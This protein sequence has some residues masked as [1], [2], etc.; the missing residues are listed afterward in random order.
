MERNTLFADVIVPLAVPKTYTYRIPQEYNEIVQPGIRVVVQFG[1][2]KLYAAV[3]KNIHSEAPKAYEAK[4]IDAILDEFPV[5]TPTQFQFW[6]WLSSYYMCHPGDVL[7]AALPGGLKISSESKII[8]NPHYEGD[9]S[10]LKDNEFLIMEAL[11]TSPVLSVQEVMQITG[12]KVVHSIIQALIKK[13][14]VILEEEVREK[15]KPKMETFLRISSTY[16]DDKQLQELFTQLEK[17]APKQLE[18]FM[19]MIVLSRRNDTVTGAVKKSEITKDL[20]GSDA[21]ITSLAK[22]GVLEVFSME[23][24]RLGAF[25]GVINESKDLNEK[26]Q[27][28]YGSIQ[29]QFA[30]KD[31]VL[32]HGV[33][34]SGKT[35][36]YIKL[37]EDTLA[38]GKQVLYLL[39]EI[40]LTTQIITRLQKI[41]GDRIGVYHSKYGENERVEVWMRMLEKDASKR[42]SV[43][44]GA[45][46]AIFLPFENLGLIIVDEEHE[47]SFK[48]FDPAPRYN[49]RDAAIMLA[50]LFKA[51]TL[52]GSATPSVE[53]WFNATSGKYGFTEILERFGGLEMPEVVVA[54][55][56]EASRKKLMQSHFTPLLLDEIKLALE[57]KEQVIIFQN[58][59]GYAP[60]LQCQMCGWVPECVSCDVSLTYHRAI[61]LLKCHY[62]GFSTKPSGSCPACG[63]TDIKM[64]GFGTEKIEDELSV[65]FPSAKIKRMDLDTTRGKHS[66]KNIIND[67]EEKKIDILVGTQ[68][69]TKGLDFD[70]VGLVG[71]LSADSML[72]FPDF[73]AHERSFQLMVQVSGRTGRKNKRGKVIIQTYQVTHPVVRQV[74]HTDYNAHYLQEL[75]ERQ[76]FN[77]PPY[78][79][80]IEITLQAKDP[81]QLNAAANFLSAQ[82]R[83]VFG[84][85]ILGP[86]SPLIPRIRN[87]YLKKLLIK[88]QRDQSHNAA[89]KRI[90]DVLE[91]FGSKQEYKAVRVVVDV[92]PM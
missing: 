33:T 47:S 77:Y 1:K 45:R 89:R 29:D 67:F 19:K 38:E 86:E 80:L 91:F 71:I 92:D 75:N 18:V 85:N 72:Q 2:K 8:K 66:Y 3:I 32:L 59:R 63:S 64:K 43:V 65:F 22:K 74:I 7:S 41:F 40:A 26:Q 68:M 6:E 16:H 21:A 13:N 31:V 24:G 78:F 37:I 15:F 14:A 27:Q 12:N 42:F 60:Q 82:L 55:M 17:K 54:D 70:N 52:L 44:L 10:E 35:E 81:D 5:I 79:K 53:S 57:N 69:V 48:Q 49:A 88:V 20:E 28:S 11:E 51:K 76:E 4:Y 83:T 36:I 61:H 58:R 46:S 34:S 25:S 62:C 56:K 87:N 73:R 84:K 50:H 23:T 9:L 39:P 30:Q 90:T